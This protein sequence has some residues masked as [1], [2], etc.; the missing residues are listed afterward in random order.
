MRLLFDTNV[1]L[2]VLL[3][4]EEF[5]LD[6]LESIKKALDR[7]DKIYVSSSAITDIYY[8]VRKNSLDKTEALEII[9]NI[10]KLFRFAEVNEQVIYSAINS[11][12]SDFEDAVV[13]SVGQ[14]ISANYIIT[15]NKLD[16]KYSIIPAINPKEYLKIGDSLQV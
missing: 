12:M 13:D 7:G 14:N 2:D 1:L 11:K 10:A 3:K 5:Y 4:R 15:R 8:I 9:K 6:S 16:F